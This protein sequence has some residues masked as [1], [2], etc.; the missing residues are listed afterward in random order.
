MAKPTVYLLTGDIGGT[1]SRMGLYSVDDNAPLV[2]KYYRNLEILTKPVD[3][4]FERNIIAPF[5]QH[6]WES[7]NSLAPL[8]QVEIVACLAI[9]GPVRNNKVCMSNLHN[10]VIDGTAIAKQMYA[11]KGEPYLARIRV[12]K[13][14]N[15]FVAQGY[16]CLTLKQ[17]EL[18]ELTPGSHN[19]IDPSGPKVCVGA[20]TGLGECF[21]T[22]D[23]EGVHTCFPSEGGHVEWAPRNELEVKLWRY[24]KEKFKYK[25]RVS[26]ERVVS[27]RGLANCYEFLAKEFPDRVDKKMHAEFETAG[28]LQGKVV[29][30]QAHAVKGSL[31][32]QA[33]EIMC[34]KSRIDASN[35]KSEVGSAGVKFIP[36][37]GLYVTGGLTPKNIQFIEGANS[38]FMKACLDKGRVTPVLDNVP[39]FAVMVED[40]GVRGAL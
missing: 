9:A 39:I 30:D 2:V 38:P 14:I 37:G 34:G 6:C 25:N 32:E 35:L 12:C 16:G 3:G 28:D 29:S 40:L 8:D 24:L 4:I 18:K 27:G 23:A 31:G 33:L 10:I 15:D 5:L 21:L 7:N 11:P 1:N 17:S 13:I 36:T 20:G 22:P 19:K 26:V